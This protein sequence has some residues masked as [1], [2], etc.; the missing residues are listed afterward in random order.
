MRVLLIKTSS[1]G[2]VLHTL[3]ALSDAVRMVPG[4]RFDWVV[5][6]A[7]ADIPRW[8][9]AVDQ[10]ISIELRK[11][12]RHFFSRENL[13]EWRACRA[14]LQ[15]NSYDL[16]L[17]AQGLIKS[18]LLSVFAKGAR[19]G[20][21]FYSARESLAALFC[22]RKYSVNFYQHAVIRMRRL[23]SLAL[24]YHLPE[25][26]PDFS[27]DRHQFKQ[28]GQ[29]ENYIVLLHSTTWRSKEW[30]ESYWRALIALITQHGLRVKIGGGSPDELARA[31]RLA[32]DFTSVDLL[33]RF[34]IDE[35]VRLLANATG[36]VAVDTGFGHL[37]AALGL[38]IVSIYGSTNPI[39]TG[40]LGDRSVHLTAQ[41]PC[42][43]CLKRACT[44]REPSSVTPACYTDLTPLRVW[45]MLA[46][47]L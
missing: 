33:P 4:I 8:H 37:A 30:P 3:P 13:H 22:Q 35:T 6:S 12:R 19:A 40:A 16:I 5:E 36:A 26:P 41:F 45:Q 25:T 7:F 32:A 43:P 47:Y 1:M 11:W 10:V 44:Y 23:F 15:A 9:P 28:V 34:S 18:A 31:K 27:L 20:L 2:D 46:V 14:L 17:D 42:A 39:W 21:D 38:P 29:T 24:N